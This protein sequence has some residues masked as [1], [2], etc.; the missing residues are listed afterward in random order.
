M[1][2]AASTPNA[3]SDGH[4]SIQEGA[5]DDPAANPPS[6][7]LAQ[8]SS[9]ARFGEIYEFSRAMAAAAEYRSNPTFET[10]WQEGARLTLAEAIDAVLER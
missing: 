4:R 5:Q 2:D 8:P 9:R 6:T 3:F 10:A 7:V 1:Q